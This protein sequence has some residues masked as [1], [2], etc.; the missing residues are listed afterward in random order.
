MEENKST[1]SYKEFV[2]DL[3]ARDDDYIVVHWLGQEVLIKKYLSL[4]EVLEFVSSVV[5]VCYQEEGDAVVY[6]P[7]VQ[8]YAVQHTMVSLYTNINLSE[9]D[10]E[11]DEEFSAYDFVTQSGIID[12][13]LEHIDYGQYDSIIKAIA[14][15]IKY[16]NEAN[17]AAIMSEIGTFNSTFNELMPQIQEL[18]NSENSEKIETALSALQIFNDNAMIRKLAMEQMKNG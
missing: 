10:D 1:I 14:S 12:L 13:I 16:I 11:E 8:T 9:S 15:K 3:M 4:L 7:E 17:S 5:D 2:A 18:F 6:K